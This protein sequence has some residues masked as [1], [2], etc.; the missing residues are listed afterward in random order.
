MQNKEYATLL[1]NN[2]KVFI[3]SKDNCPLCEQLKI[4][5]ETLEVEFKTFIYEETEDEINNDFHFKKTMKTHTGANLFPFCYING[6]YVGGYK[7]VHQNLM[8]GKL[9][10]QLNEIGIEYEEDF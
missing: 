5:F 8:T 1:E 2:K 4:L 10:E 7:Q 9:K 3:I 6:V